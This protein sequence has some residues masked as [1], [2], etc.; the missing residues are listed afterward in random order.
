MT[1]SEV[2]STMV[3]FQK[4]SL[5]VK[6]WHEGLKTYIYGIHDL[7]LRH[8]R[9]GLTQKE[10]IDRHRSYINK[11]LAICNGDYSKLPRDNY[12]YSYIGYHLKEGELFEKF[13]EIYLDFDF[14]QSKIYENGPG[15]L[16]IDL[17]KYRK[18]ISG[19]SIEIA[20]KVEDLKQ[21]LIQ[22]ASTLAEYR[23]RNCLDIV[24][25]ALNHPNPGFVRNTAEIL[26]NKTP[27]G[28]YFKYNKQSTKNSNP[29]DVLQMKI[30][31]VAFTNEP[32]MILV[33][34]ENGKVVWWNCR[35][36]R[37]L[38]FY[39]N[40]ADSPVKKIV[41][42]KESKFFISLS[43]SG[44]A[45]LF[46]LKEPFEKHHESYANT[47]QWTRQTSYQSLH[48]APRNHDES[49][50]TIEINGQKITDVAVSSDGEKIAT[51]TY[52]GYVTVSL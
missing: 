41:F 14:I 22:Q 33:G 19:N 7:M 21:F 45:K 49:R 38:F 1:S 9:K 10:L 34:T 17:K 11:N 25:I 3:K 30:C 40:K 16:L 8:L 5:A 24:Q 20:S 23:T 50:M 36:R 32:V 37:H 39:G 43:E 31:S 29:T 52:A 35:N 6:Q 12:I 42:S 28:L 51:C 15:N 18:Y 46:D 2:D 47:E 13:S 44:I 48:G 26:A 4:K 27:Q